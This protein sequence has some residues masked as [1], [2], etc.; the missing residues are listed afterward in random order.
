MACSENQLEI[1]RFLLEKGVSIN[2]KDQSCYTPLRC[3]VLSRS[4]ENLIRELRSKGGR[5]EMSNSEIFQEITW[6]I[7]K[8]DVGLLLSYIQAGVDVNVSVVF[9]G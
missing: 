8:N 6:A 3:A 4:N 7:H 2:C 1:V 5:I 9:I